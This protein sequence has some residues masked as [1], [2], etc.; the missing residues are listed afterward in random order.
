MKP[1]INSTAASL[2]L[3]AALLASPR[4]ISAELG[5]KFRD[6]QSQAMGRTGIASSQGATALF[7]NPAGLAGNTKISGGFVA[8]LGVNSILLDYASW[9]AKNYKYLNTTDSL[10]T[11]IGEVDN[12]W[13]PFSQSTMIYGNI[14]GTAVAAVID[15]RYDLTI[16]KAVVTP[17]PGVGALSDL[18]V[19][20]GRGYEAPEGYRFGFALKYFYRL[21]LPNQLV[22]TTD[23]AFYKVKNAWQQPDHGWSDKLKKIG[24]AGDI[25]ETKQA[26]GI[27]LGAEKIV[28]E[29]WTA[30]ISLLDFPTLMDARFVKPDINLGLSFH[31]DL[32]LVEE[33]DNKI[34]VNLDY[35]KFLIPGTPW[36]KQIKTGMALEGYMNKRQVSYVG[37]GLND[38]Y[39]SFG[40]R[41]GY[42]LYLSYVYIAEEIG[43]YPGQEKLSFHKLALQLEI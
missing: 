41:F 2:S 18:I 10:L 30:G 17:V 6:L 11:T 43:T 23:D 25:A 32:D 28:N 15:T 42:I 4:W 31:H 36:F 26:F 24:V 39:P 29:N 8:D 20:V 3:I 5:P 27:N 35:Q 40:L 13:A 7:L 9:A 21:S 1:M 14:Q 12:K 37:L 34:I 16:G 33:L 38:G 19:T 22:G